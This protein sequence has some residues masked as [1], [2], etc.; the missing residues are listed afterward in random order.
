MTAEEWAGWIVLSLIGV[1]LVSVFTAGV[2]V[3]LLV[4]GA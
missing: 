4:A 2:I 3:G 1:I